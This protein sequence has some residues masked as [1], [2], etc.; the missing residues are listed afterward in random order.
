MARRK[1]RFG[2]PAGYLMK[3][4][5]SGLCLVVLTT[6]FVVSAFAPGEDD[7]ERLAALGESLY[8]GHCGRCHGDDGDAAG[9]YQ[10]VPLAGIAR[11]PP[12]GLVGRFQQES[13]ST[14][15][16]EFSGERARALDLHLARLRGAKGFPDPGWLWSPYLLER[17]AASAQECRVVDVRRPEDYAR[18]R[19]PNAV[20]LHLGEEER[21]GVL[22]RGRVEALLRQLG[23]GELT[24]VV[25]YDRYG[26][27]EAA[28]LWWTLVDA[29]H[30]HVALLDGGWENWVARGLSVSRATPRI[31]PRGYIPT[32]PV[33]GLEG[34]GGVPVR[35]IQWD[36]RKVTGPKG[37]KDAEAIRTYLDGVGID[38]EAEGSYRAKGSLG[39]GAFLLFLARVLGKN[40]AIRYDDRDRSFVRI[41]IRWDWR[42]SD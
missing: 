17:K 26:G 23:V 11:R 20:S 10:I 34:L 28:W 42:G 5:L 30:P 21:G 24:Q 6:S 32:S 31:E 16:V 7:A 39:E 25:V 2:A 35:E 18:G 1:V 41:D 15:G 19:V 3:W 9:Y 14:R 4:E 22:P 38:L 37:L 29:G 8:L 33:K 13:F 36:W 12:V 40:G 27:P